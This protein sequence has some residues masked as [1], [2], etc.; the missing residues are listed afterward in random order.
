MLIKQRR[1]YR[2]GTTWLRW[3]E[4]ASDRDPATLERAARLPAGWNCASCRPEDQDWEGATAETPVPKVDLIY[5]CT[6]C[7][8]VT[9]QGRLATAR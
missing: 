3:V 2:D 9:Y 7:G 1:T 8:G 4:T 6:A 5:E